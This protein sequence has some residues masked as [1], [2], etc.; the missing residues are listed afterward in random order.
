VSDAFTEWIA[1]AGSL[2]ACAAKIRP[3]LDLKVDRITFALLPGGR[4]ARLRQYGA[5]LIPRLLQAVGGAG[6]R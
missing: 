2:D 4:E 1:V 3:L 5:E 6:R